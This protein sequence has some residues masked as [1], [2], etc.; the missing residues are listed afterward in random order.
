M[1][2]TTLIISVLLRALLLH[3]ENGGKV[4][5][6]VVAQALDLAQKILA[7][8]VMVPPTSKP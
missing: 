1:Q 7:D 2:Y 8:P 6:P 5:H 4:N 3:F